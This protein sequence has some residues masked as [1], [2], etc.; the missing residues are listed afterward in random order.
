MLIFFYHL[1]SFF[2]VLNNN[3]TLLSNLGDFP[4]VFLNMHSMREDS[5]IQH[6]FF[7]IEVTSSALSMKCVYVVKR[8]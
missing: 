1:L 4:D 7:S 8:I 5:I 6:L 2:L 3:E